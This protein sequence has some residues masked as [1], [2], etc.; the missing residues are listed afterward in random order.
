MESAVVGGSVVGQQP[1]C[2]ELL[3]LAGRVASAVVMVATQMAVRPLGLTLAELS[4]AISK[5]SDF[6]LRDFDLV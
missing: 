5:S 6:A 1:G 4:A 3:G 2:M